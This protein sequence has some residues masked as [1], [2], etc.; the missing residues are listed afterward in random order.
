M[1]EGLKEF[2]IISDFREEDESSRASTPSSSSLAIAPHPLGGSSR[3]ISPTKECPPKLGKRSSSVDCVGSSSSVGTS[4][5]N[6]SDTWNIFH[7]LRGKIAKRVE[8][9]LSKSDK[10]CRKQSAK[11]ASGRGSLESSS[12]SDSEDGCIAVVAEEEAVHN[13]SIAGASEDKDDTPIAT[14]YI[15]EGE[16]DVKG[17]Q[18]EH[19][20]RRMLELRRRMKSKEKGTALLSVVSSSSLFSRQEQKIQAEEEDDEDEEFEVLGADCPEEAE[21]VKE[22]TPLVADFE[23]RA[24]LSTPTW[25]LH[26]SPCNDYPPNNPNVSPLFLLFGWSKKNVFVLFSLF[27]ICPFILPSFLSGILV[28]FSISVAVSL[29]V[30]WW[31]YGSWLP[32][33]TQPLTNISEAFIVP[34]YGRLPILEVPA[35]KEYQPVPR[36]EGWMNQYLHEYDPDTY[37]V[38]ATASVL[39]RLEGHILRL[40]YTRSRVPRRAMW[41]ETPSFRPPICHWRDYN[42]QGC[43]IILCPEGLAR[44][45]LWSKKYPICIALKKDSNISLNYG[46][47]EED[48]TDKNED[49][50]GDET[51]MYMKDSDEATDGE[52]SIGSGGNF[53]TLASEQNDGEEDQ[54]S[55]S[56]EETFCPIGGEVIKNP[57]KCLY[58]FARTD[59][60]KDD[61]D[62]KDHFGCSFARV[63]TITFVSKGT[64]EHVFFF[65]VAIYSEELEDSTGL[66]RSSTSSLATLGGSFKSSVMLQLFSSIRSFD[67][68]IVTKLPSRFRRFVAAARYVQTPVDDASI[69]D[70]LDIEGENKFTIQP[71]PDDSCADFSSFSSWTDA[72]QPVDAEFQ[73]FIGRFLTKVSKFRHHISTSIG[74]ARGLNPAAYSAETASGTSSPT[75]SVHGG[76]KKIPTNDSLDKEDKDLDKE[77]VDGVAED[78]KD[79]MSASSVGISPETLWA[80]AMLARVLFDVLRDRFWVD[81]IQER[82]QRKLSAIKV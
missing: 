39:V 62:S 77:S 34:D 28:G 47:E 58:L 26:G 60:E 12:I 15:P 32:S 44:K 9:T 76:S 18:G 10:P 42:I 55:F 59:R 46:T 1:Y 35:A 80:N 82:I 13:E 16:T 17:G 54:W 79:L 78:D 7:E 65:G 20:P 73:K 64:V 30:H 25:T 67:Y 40:S 19:F 8:E 72:N 14:F 31:Y 11:L 36:Y 70:D 45:R 74:P 23:S 27:I 48:L 61:W 50:G 6:I 81:K 21:E 29:F 3:E 22:E 56:E 5:T 51:E 38:G 43:T 69:P 53:Q 63:T 66:I 75:H 57:K 41:N 24:Q 33:P 49:I 2:K 37:H 52:T 71:S 68:N 4:S